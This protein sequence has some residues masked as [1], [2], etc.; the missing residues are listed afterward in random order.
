MSFQNDLFHNHFSVYA[1]TENPSV[2]ENFK[3]GALTSDIGNILSNYYSI[4]GDIQKYNDKKK[5]LNDNPNSDFSNNKLDY[6]NK[7]KTFYDG[8]QEDVQVM[9]VHQYNM[10]M[11]GLITTST[12]IVFAILLAREQ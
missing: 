8:T 9:L 6:T 7:T 4:S 11:A 1:S 5:N 12:L 3:E 2:K 10:Y